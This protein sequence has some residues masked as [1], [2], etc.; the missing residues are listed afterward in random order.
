MIP[1]IMNCYER[2]DLSLTHHIS[3]FSLIK[4]LPHSY[5]NNLEFNVSNTYIGCNSAKKLLFFKKKLQPTVIKCES[6]S[7]SES[8]SEEKDR[9]LKFE[10]LK[11]YL[12]NPRIK[13]KSIFEISSRLFR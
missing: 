4:G 2:S 11:T 1:G 5:T 8:E 9:E 13:P 7:E 12:S 10:L 6:E 3:K